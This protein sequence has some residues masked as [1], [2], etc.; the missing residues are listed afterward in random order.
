MPHP[1]PNSQ[2]KQRSG[3][4]VFLRRGRC[5]VNDFVTLGLSLRLTQTLVEDAV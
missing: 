5:P 4:A 2:C 3:A 1:T